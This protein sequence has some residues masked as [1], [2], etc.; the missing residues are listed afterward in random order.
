MDERNIEQIIKDINE[1]NVNLT[2]DNLVEMGDIL[3]GFR[4]LLALS[5]Y[6][7]AIDPKYFK[8][9]LY[10][11]EFSDLICLEGAYL[12]ALVKAYGVLG[13][14][15]N[16]KQFI[17]IANSFSHKRYHRIQNSE[18]DM[19]IILA[20]ESAGKKDLANSFQEN[21]GKRNDIINWGL[22][23]YYRPE[24]QTLLNEIGYLS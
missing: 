4:P 18:V 22:E 6:R 12:Y 20:F 17:Q 7:Q 14:K 16:K 24:L 9:P 10:K 5:A 23:K 1:G 11:D 21:L 15:F 2:R 13:K 3:L 8:I 19:S